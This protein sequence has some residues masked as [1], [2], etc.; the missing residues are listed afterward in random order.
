MLAAQQVSGGT[1]VRLPPYSRLA[2]DGRLT[3]HR[4]NVD[5]ALPW[6][7]LAPGRSH[8]VTTGGNITMDRDLQAADDH[9]L[10]LTSSAK[11]LFI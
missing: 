9:D 2:P 11:V 1:G 3:L 5:S 10:T 8:H 4:V 6:L 7:W